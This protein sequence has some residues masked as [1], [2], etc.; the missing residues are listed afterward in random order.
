MLYTDIIFSITSAQMSVL[1]GL[2]DNF[3]FPFAKTHLKAKVVAQHTNDGGTLLVRDSIE[4]LL[5]LSWRVY[6]NLKYEQ[7]VIKHC[8]SEPV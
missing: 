5:D 1:T 3:L 7:T 4:N 2:C 8:C 6:N